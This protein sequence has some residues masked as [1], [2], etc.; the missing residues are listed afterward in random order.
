MEKLV[1]CTKC[2]VEKVQK[3]FPYNKN[4]GYSTICR[5][6]T[7]A[8]ARDNY[9]KRT[10]AKPDLSEKFC[11]SCNTTKSVQC[12]PK[13]AKRADGLGSYCSDCFSLHSKK[14][15]EKQ[16]ANKNKPIILS[17]RCP[18][19]EVEKPAREYNKSNSR[20]DGLR[21]Q[22]RSCQRERDAL[23]LER[24]R[25][26][27]LNIRAERLAKG[28]L[29]FCSSCK[30]NKPYES[31]RQDAWAKDGTSWQCSMCYRGYYYANLEHMLELNT[32][33]RE[34]NREK[35]KEYS[36]WYEQ[37]K[38]DSSRNR[39]YFLLSEEESE[40]RQFPTKAKLLERDGN[41]CY[42]CAVVLDFNSFHKS[43]FIHNQAHLE[44]LTPLSRGGEHTFSNTVLSCARCNLRKGKKTEEEYYDWLEILNDNSG[45]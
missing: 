30:E 14:Y 9:N 17:K 6:C 19:C 13:N 36:T 12:W 1:R 29:K 16:K 38:R 11:P 32:L 43:N 2:C 40:A 10:S 35:L 20:K 7:N 4:R 23:D 26:T 24:N 34:T 39:G 33:Y 41:T 27:H 31:F 15:R 37:N 28:E 25:E 45:V 18:T 3:D 22:C 5:I 8:R 44:H 21:W 42:Y